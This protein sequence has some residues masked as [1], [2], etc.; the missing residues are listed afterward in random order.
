MHG[1]QVGQVLVQAMVEELVGGSVSSLSVLGGICSALVGLFRDLIRLTLH[2][3][4]L[5]SLVL[6][7]QDK[8]EA[9]LDELS[10]QVDKLL[11]EHATKVVE[12]FH[13]AVKHR[14]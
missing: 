7:S 6:E 11:T 2:V 10:W 14:T 5:L 1:K 9:L 8:A 12:S 13:A 4:A 3:P